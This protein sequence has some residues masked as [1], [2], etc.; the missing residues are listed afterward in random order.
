MIPPIPTIVSENTVAKKKDNGN[1]S[2]SSPPLS[3]GRKARIYP[4]L[5]IPDDPTLKQKQVWCTR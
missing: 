4:N 3:L 5:S 2:R 1:E